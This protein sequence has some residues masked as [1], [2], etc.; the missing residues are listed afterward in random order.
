MGTF[1]RLNFL[2]LALVS[3]TSQA[4]L[5]PVH[6]YSQ[7]APHTNTFPGSGKN[8]DDLQNS[9]I[10]KLSPYPANHKPTAIPQG[11]EPHW[12]DG[13]LVTHGPGKNGYQ[14]STH[15]ILIGV[16]VL[17]IAIW[18]VA[19][20]LIKINEQ[21]PNLGNSDPKL[22]PAPIRDT[23]ITPSLIVSFFWN[24]LLQFFYPGILA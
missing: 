24:K 22:E 20:I 10:Q 2:V 8:G 19:T 9:A 15:H 23:T 17:I 18:L 16:A 1:L 14:H 11:L 12:H 21:D 4:D 7:I 13:K 3:L 6:P 5:P